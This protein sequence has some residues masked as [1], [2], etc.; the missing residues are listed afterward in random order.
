MAVNIAGHDF[1]DSGLQFDRA[2]KRARGF[3]EEDAY[4]RAGNALRQNNSA[5]ARDALLG[6]GMIGDAQQL[7]DRQ[8]AQQ[9]ARAAADAQREEQALKFTLDAASRLRQL[10]DDERVPVEQKRARVLAGFDQLAPQWARMGETPEELAELRQRLEQD[11]ETTL[12]VLGAGA[13]KQAGLDIVKGSDGSYVAVDKATGRPAYKF[14]APTTTKLGPGD[15]LLEIPGSEGPEQPAGADWLDNVHE[16]APDAQVTS[17]LRTPQRNAE[18]GGK[19]DSRHLDNSALDLVPRPGETMAQLYARVRGAKGAKAI[20]EG[21]H[22]HVQ[23]TAPRVIASR[24]EKPKVQQVRLTPEETRAG[25]YQEGSVVFRNP[26]TGEETVKQGPGGGS[27]KI[28]DGA[29]QGASLAYAAFAGNERMNELARRGVYKP[30]SPIESLIKPD[31]NGFIRL[32]ARN[33]QDRAFIQAATEYLAPILRKDTGAAVTYQEFMFYKDILI[34]AFEDNP[35]LL[36]QKAQARDA[37]LRRIYGSSR[38]AYDEEYGAPG[39]WSI[40]TDPQGKPGGQPQ[41]PQSGSVI[42]YD[43]R[44]NRIK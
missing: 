32:T 31:S 2:Y 36:W 19:A 18:V 30:T 5:A 42:R 28:T 11:P 24:P 44:G 8:A 33:P 38:R 26:E 35:E 39:K 37:Q 21:D 13:A 27:G 10:H 3:R 12:T 40:L 20:N 4:R 41:G 15:Q 43:T 7:E 29:R 22:V 34:P 9:R 16:A 6:E 25:G 1:G 17:G 14:R 23:S